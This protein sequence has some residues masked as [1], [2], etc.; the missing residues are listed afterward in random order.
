MGRRVVTAHTEGGLEKAEDGSETGAEAGEI[1][2]VVEDEA[3][4]LFVVVG[5]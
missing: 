2:E 4:G 3:G 1:L 5:R